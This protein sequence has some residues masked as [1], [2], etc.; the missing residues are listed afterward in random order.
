M[1]AIH[2]KLTREEIDVL[3][4]EAIRCGFQQPAGLPEASLSERKLAIRFLMQ[5]YASELIEKANAKT[6][7]QKSKGKPKAKD[8]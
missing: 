1:I 7:P 3:Y 2:V 6:N 5:D 8:G 4:L